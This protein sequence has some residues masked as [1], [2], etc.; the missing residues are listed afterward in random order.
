MGY[1]DVDEDA[2]A[3][4]PP[5]PPVNPMQPQWEPPEGNFDPYFANIQLSI[6]SQF[7]QMQSGFNSA[8]GQQMNNTFQAMQ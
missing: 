5:P 8:Y 6:T 3:M 7:Q 2:H 1:A 4:P